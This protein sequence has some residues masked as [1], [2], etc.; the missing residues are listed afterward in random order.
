MYK[1]IYNIY[2]KTNLYEILTFSDFCEPLNPID[3]FL[4]PSEPNLIPSSNLSLEINRSYL[5]KKRFRAFESFL[6]EDSRAELIYKAV[7]QVFCLNIKDEEKEENNVLKSKENINFKNILKIN[8]EN[9]RKEKIQKIYGKNLFDNVLKKVQVH[10]IKFIINISN[11]AIETALGNKKG[12]FFIDIDYKIK[13]TINFIFFESLKSLKIKDIIQNPKSKKFKLYPEDYNESVY[14]EIINLSEWL[15][16]FFNIGYLN[17]FEIYFN[18]GKQL[19]KI[20]FNGK[21][22]I[23]GEKTKSFY[24]LIKQYESPFEELIINFTE[25]AYFG[26]KK[27]KKNK[28]LL[29]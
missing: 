11:D 29:N 3:S 16:E 26:E 19:N 23:L 7:N 24:E 15:K 9:K 27:E 1:S 12:F 6:N 4:I 18:N 20:E 5:E 22:I 14:N 13:S 2:E 25:T 17:L 28:I 10:Y 8:S 21:E